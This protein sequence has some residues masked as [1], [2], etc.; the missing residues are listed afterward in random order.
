[1][2][3]KRKAIR[4]CLMDVYCILSFQ[5]LSLTE[6]LMHL[7]SYK[8]VEDDIFRKHIPDYLPKVLDHRYQCL[9]YAIYYP[10]AATKVSCA[11]LD[12]LM[13]R[14]C[15]SLPALT[16]YS[17]VTFLSILFHKAVQSLDTSYEAPPSMI[18]SVMSGVFARFA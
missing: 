16:P 10:L 15:K 9:L 17:T 2:L 7:P 14:R 1:M 6:Y 8:M 12:L 18:S 3:D 11:M 5:E 13:T 4:C